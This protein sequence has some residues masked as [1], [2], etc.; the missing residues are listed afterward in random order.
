MGITCGI[1][2][3]D[4]VAISILK[5]YI[6]KVPEM[7]LAFA[8][9]SA[10]D[11]ASNIEKFKPDLIFLDVEM[12]HLSGLELL[13][14]LPQKPTV[15]ITSAKKEYA[16]DGFE[17]DVLDYMVK[18]VTFHRFMKSIN[19]FNQA[20]TNTQHAKNIASD[21]IF[22]NENKK[23]VK[24]QMADILYVESL[25]D[26]IKI[27]T[28]KRHVTTKEQI[29]A[30]ADKLPESMFLRIHRSYLIAINHIDSFNSS[31]VE[32]NNLELPIGRI[33]KN[34]CMQ[35]LENLGV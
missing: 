33:Y 26:Y 13:Y 32:I 15:I 6:V 16:V 30:F 14:S 28:T 21:W 7:Q 22:V 2:D 24:I 10:L 23:M 12:P 18:P 9:T 20:F 5:N 17:L 11:A 8:I 27:H 25:K 29:S 4:A 3:D 1:I 35:I 19:K 34:N 31:M